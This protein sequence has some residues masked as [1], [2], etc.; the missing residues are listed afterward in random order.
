[1]KQKLVASF[2]FLLLCGLATWAFSRVICQ[3][4]RVPYCLS[5]PGHRKFQV[6]PSTVP[7]VEHG[8]TVFCHLFTRYMLV[9]NNLELGSTNTSTA[10]YNETQDSYHCVLEDEKD[11]NWHF[12]TVVLPDHFV[13]S[14]GTY[15][16]NNP[17]LRIT[18]AIA[19]EYSIE[20]TD[21]SEVSVHQEISPHRRMA[22]KTGSPTAIFIRVLSTS[23]HAPANS[24]DELRNGI[25]GTGPNPTL[26]NP[27]RQYAACSF[28][29][30]RIQP[31]TIG[32]NVRGGVLDVVVNR[33]IDGSC[34]LNGDCM[35][36]IKR[37]TEA[38][39]ARSLDDYDIVWW[40]VPPGVYSSG[41][42]GWDAFAYVGKQ[43]AFFSSGICSSLSTVAH[44]T[45]HLLGFGHSDTVNGPRGDFTCLLG[46]SQSQYGGPR[47]CLNGQK[48]SLSRWME[49]TTTW[50]D[51]SKGGFKG[52]LFAFVDRSKIPVS[53]PNGDS[54]LLAFP[55]PS[56]YDVFVLYNR[57]KSFNDGAREGGDLVT[58][59]QVS[60]NRNIESIRLAMLDAYQSIKIPGTNIFVRVCGKRNSL[61]MGD[62]ALM[63]IYDRSR[64]QV[65]LCSGDFRLTTGG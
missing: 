52:R 56:G 10:S 21:N 41:V 37:V 33:P 26:Y 2:L 58:V 6:A 9:S 16:S 19:G 57:K 61:S 48:Y 25:M 43:Q 14:H 17:V 54:T 3:R 49:S 24:A 44:E 53:N 55:T 35:A 45:G 27:L 51:L 1:M 30:L 40:C 4:G 13:Q 47:F 59:V 50:V 11:P 7:E 32:N 23:G 5:L 36:E 12:R 22:P 65:S 28:G 34:D 39:L 8:Q 38:T 62:R 46:G 64:G 63:T 20:L 60:P 15:L 31:A 29:Q 18:H 42:D